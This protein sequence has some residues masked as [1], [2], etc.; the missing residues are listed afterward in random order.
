MLRRMSRRPYRLV[1]VGLGPSL[2]NVFTGTRRYGHPRPHA[3]A[4]IRARGPWR[5]LVKT[6]RRAAFSQLGESRG[7]LT[8]WRVPRRRARSMLRRRAA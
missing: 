7:G 1:R 8:G 6:L 4:R 5:G 2:L 3:R